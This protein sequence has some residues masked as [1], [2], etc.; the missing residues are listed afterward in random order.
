MIA[1]TDF[2][3]YYDILIETSAGTINLGNHH[4]LTS[5]TF[6][7]PGCSVARLKLILRY[8]VLLNNLECSD[9]PLSILVSKILD[10]ALS[11]TLS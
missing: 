1:H 5:S 10:V 8:F 7:Y 11:K 2:S 4:V 9:K 3:R 6:Y